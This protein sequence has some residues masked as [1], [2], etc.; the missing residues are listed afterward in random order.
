MSEVAHPAPESLRAYEARTPRRQFTDT[1]GNDWSYRDNGHAGTALPL[2][3]LPGALGTGSAAWHV[4]EAFEEER[5]VVAVT[6]PGGIAPEALADG[7]H[8]LLASLG[9]GPIALWGSSYGAWWAQ[10]FA[11]RHRAQ[12]A[13]LWLGNTLVDGADVAASPLFDA[14][15]LDTAT[16]GAVMARW[17]GA[18]SA[19]PA[20]P[21][22]TVQLHMHMLHHGLPAAAFRGRLRQVANA[23]AP[24]AATDIASTVVCDCED[25][26]TITPQVRERVRARYPAAH[27]LTLASG[28]HYPHIVTPEPLIAAMRSWLA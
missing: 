25:D 1:A 9:I 23:V 6:Y 22:R 18:L 21:L 24:Q 8:A 14:A 4:A 10:V 7:L 27:R 19:R 28:G 13:A 2:V 17:H 20:D 5:R 3:L 11:T 26:P 15:W 12:A 16:A